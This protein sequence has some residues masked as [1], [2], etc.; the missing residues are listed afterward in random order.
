MSNPPGVATKSSKLKK[1]LLRIVITIIVIVLAVF[2]AFKVSPWP[3]AML[4]RRVFNKEGVRVNEALKKHVPANITETLN[5]SYDTSDEDA[6]LDVYYPSAITNTHEK[7]PVIVW[8]HGGGWVAGNKQQLSSYCKIVAGK[9][10]VVVPIDYSLAPGKKYPTPLRQTN[11]ALAWLNENASRLH[12]DTSRFILAGDSGGAHIVSQTANIISSSEY[13]QLTGITPMLNPSQLAGLLLYCGP[14]SMEEVDLKGGFGSFLK[15]VL[16][17]YSGT[18]DFAT[19][20]YFKTGS[21]INYIT[22]H[23]PPCFISAGNGD[24]LLP[25]SQSLA[26]KLSSLNVYVDTFFFPAGLQPALPHEYQF[27]LDTDGGQQALTHSL[28]F[29][30]HINAKKNP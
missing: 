5:L 2:I 18:K 13:A 1:A 4:I 15:T 12:I 29:L 17:S 24:L 9:G 22:P 21:V 10:F 23:Y 3:S 11:K 27:N 20:P 8:V 25:H 26:R 7:L 19:D 30:A 14:Y 28:D 6:L 16:W